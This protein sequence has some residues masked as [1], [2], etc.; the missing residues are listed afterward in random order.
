MGRLIRGKNRQNSRHAASKYP[1]HCFYISIKPTIN[2]K[3]S[4]C[5]N[6]FRSD[7]IFGKLNYDGEAVVSFEMKRD[8]S[9]HTELKRYSVSS[10]NFSK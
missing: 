1:N 7:I 4:F 5:E 9:N 2:R 10:L 8:V 3:E 6:C